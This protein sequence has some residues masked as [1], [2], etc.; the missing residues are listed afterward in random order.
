MLP[1]TIYCYMINFIVTSKSRALEKP[2]IVMDQLWHLVSYM[3][4]TRTL[5]TPPCIVFNISKALSA[6]V[7]SFITSF[8]KGFAASFLPS[9]PEIGTI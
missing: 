4:H 7:L 8:T 3:L 5:Y 2:L 9:W 6:F 1:V